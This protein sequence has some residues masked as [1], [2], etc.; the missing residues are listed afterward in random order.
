MVKP[1][2]QAF[3]HCEVYGNPKPTVRWHKSSQLDIRSDSRYDTFSNGTLLIRQATEQDMDSYT[4]TAD[5]GVSS[6]VEKTIKLVLRGN[7]HF[8]LLYIVLY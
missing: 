2:R 8:T 3:L 4:C 7:T 1:N 6:P 5:N